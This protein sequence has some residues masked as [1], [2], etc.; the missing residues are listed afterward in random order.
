MAIA[1][2]FV[3]GYWKKAPVIAAAHVIAGATT[4]IAS[5]FTDYRAYSKRRR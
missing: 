3:L 1:A 5:L 2:P 4:I